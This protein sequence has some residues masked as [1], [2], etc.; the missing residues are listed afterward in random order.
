MPTS[1]F[2]NLPQEKKDV[3][4]AAARK[5][6]A[7]ATFK[8]ASIN[9]IIQDAKIPRG[10][11]YMYF[12]DKKDLLYCLLSEYVTLMMG[13]V[14]KALKNS[15]GDIF[16]VFIDMYDFTIS[17]STTAKEEMAILTNLF[18]SMHSSGLRPD[19]DIDMQ[20]L[21]TL[22]NEIPK[23]AEAMKMMDLEN[24][25]IKNLDDWEDLLA[26]LFSITKHSISQTLFNMPDLSPVSSCF[27]HIPGGTKFH[28]MNG[29]PP[30]R[31]RFMNMI[32]IVKYGVIKR[33]LIL[34]TE[35]K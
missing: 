26:I 1:T 27:S 35:N 24:S 31:E 18:T 12:K 7:R 6:F 20:E 11:F 10:S 32:N 33:D 28:G 16:A 14:E 30:T 21:F 17:Y 9:K 4:L 23:H 25:N 22:K 8:E 19:E 15:N 29:S 34:E 2:N 5:E 13:R 3:I